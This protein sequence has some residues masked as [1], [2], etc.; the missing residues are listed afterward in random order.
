MTGF[1]PAHTWLDSNQQCPKPNSGTLSI[2]SH[3]AL[4]LSYMA[5]KETWEQLVTCSPALQ[6]ILQLAN[7]SNETKFILTAINCH[8]TCLLLLKGKRKKYSYNKSCLKKYLIYLINLA[9]GRQLNLLKITD[10]R[11]KS[12]TL[13]HCTL[14]LCSN[15]ALY[16]YALTLHSTTVL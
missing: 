11:T 16:H 3:D 15:T 1:E 10:N 13:Y 6:A 8:T 5:D 2:R 4:P 12:I 7:S 9:F 14:P